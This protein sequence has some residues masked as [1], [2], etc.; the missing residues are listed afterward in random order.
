M[1]K[2]TL[3]EKTDLAVSLFGGKGGKSSRTVK[4]K[5]KAVAK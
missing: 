5:P 4:D 3:G 1:S 2:L